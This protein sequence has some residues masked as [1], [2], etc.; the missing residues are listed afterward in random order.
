[1]Y[2]RSRTRENA[3][4]KLRKKYMTWNMK[5][6]C[7]LDS[8]P[9]IQAVSSF[10]NVQ[11]S[12]FLASVIRNSRHKPEG[13]R[14]SFNYKVLT[15]TLLKHGL[16][17]YKFL[18][19]LFRLPFRWSLQKHFA[20]GWVSIPMCWIVC[21]VISKWVTLLGYY[22]RGLGGMYGEKYSGGGGRFIEFMPY[23]SKRQPP[24]ACIS[25]GHRDISAT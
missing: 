4:C 20:L 1:M 3:L 6:V 17:S 9:L 2:D 25:S 16:K 19:S 8:F 24:R 22:K 18:N 23:S 11:T 13:R 10:L 12:R 21:L 14:W 7:Q 15:L 5:E